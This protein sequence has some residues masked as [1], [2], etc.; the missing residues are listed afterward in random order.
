MGRHSE[1]WFRSVLLLVGMSLAF[2]IP[3]LAGPPLVCHPINI[4][5]A[6]SL[7]WPSD[8]GGMVGRT[9]YDVSHLVQDTLSI[10]RPD[11]DVLVR[12]ETLRRATIYAQR[13]AVVAKELM[14]RLHA[15]T[16]EN[17]ND[18]LAAFDFGYLVECYKQAQSARA[19]GLTAWRHTQWS[20]PAANVDGYGFVE[21]AIRMQ[22]QDAEM[23]F[24]AALITEWGSHQQDFQRHVEHAVA[25]AGG[26]ALLA[27]NLSAHFGRR[28]AAQALDKAAADNQ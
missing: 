4:G 7:P 19:L 20:N 26:N 11:T 28:V 25:G 18:A 15:R 12:M 21:K 6:T 9:D 17:A 10:L 27:D 1:V 16:T 3:A 5:R 23:E 2:V 24:A 14:L 8:G 13:N 22:A